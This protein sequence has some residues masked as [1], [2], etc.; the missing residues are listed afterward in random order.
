LE[1]HACSRRNAF[2]ETLREHNASECESVMAMATLRRCKPAFVDAWKNGG[3]A[4]TAS[5]KA[6]ASQLVKRGR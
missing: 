2:G 4:L 6:A 3:A 1:A 5:P